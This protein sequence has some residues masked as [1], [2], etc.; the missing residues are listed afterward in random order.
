M[1]EIASNLGDGAF[2]WIK[3]FIEKLP[4]IKDNA[5]N[6]KRINTIKSLSYKLHALKNPS[7]ICKNDEE[8]KEIARLESRID[9]AIYALYGLDDKQIEIIESTFIAGGG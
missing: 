1:K 3:Q 7:K 5:Q 4:V 6:K 9:S 2:R 8:E